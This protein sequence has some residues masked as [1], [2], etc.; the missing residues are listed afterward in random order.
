MAVF[1]LIL[2]GTASLPFILQNTF[3]RSYYN[4]IYPWSQPARIDHHFIRYDDCHDG[5]FF[6]T[7]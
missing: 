3:I 2:T 7:S 1:Y 4:S 6:Y 5:S